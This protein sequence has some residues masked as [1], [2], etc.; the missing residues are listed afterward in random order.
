MTP[1]EW[2]LIAAA[3]I[4]MIGFTFGFFIWRADN[5]QADVAG[6]LVIFYGLFWPIAFLLYFP[7]C[8][9]EFV[10]SLISKN[11]VK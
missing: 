2:L 3:Y 11:K 1:F 6:W 8:I 5:L 10:A 4:A 9:G 7:Y